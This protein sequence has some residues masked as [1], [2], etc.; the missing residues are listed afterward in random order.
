MR[1][2]LMLACLSLAACGPDKGR[3]LKAHNETRHVEGYTSIEPLHIGEI[4]IYTSEY[5]PPYDYEEFVCDQWEFPNGRMEK[6]D[7]KVGR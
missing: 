3:C 5:H 2:M 7:P 6:D 1:L 4:T